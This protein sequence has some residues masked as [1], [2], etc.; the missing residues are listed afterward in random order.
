MNPPLTAHP[1]MISIHA[2]IHV[3]MK[4]DDAQDHSVSMLLILLFSHFLPIS[5]LSLLLHFFA[6][7]SLCTDCVDVNLQFKHFLLA[8]SL[9]IYSSSSYMGSFDAMCPWGRQNL[10]G[11]SWCQCPLTYS[12]C[13]S[14]RAHGAALNSNQ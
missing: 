4:T 12:L 1:I 9:L 10:R 7:S 3:D 14:R 11:S 13:C 5:L 6:I 2:S 8:H